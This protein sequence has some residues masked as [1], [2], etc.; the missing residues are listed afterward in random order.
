MISFWVPG[1]PQA[2]KRHRMT[3]GGHTYDPSAGDKADFLAKAMAHR[4]EAPL[5]GPVWLKV[6]AFFP[7]PKYYYRANG[8][9]KKDAPTAQSKR[10]DC[11]NILKFV[12]DALNGIFWTDDAQICN[13]SVYKA[14]DAV[15][16]VRVV[17][18]EGYAQPTV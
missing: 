2:L 18:G 15:P 8:E 4:P 13:A 10:P 11:D 1:K 3:K 12:A 14:Y 17:M 16:G 6:F 9:L 5:R 7:R